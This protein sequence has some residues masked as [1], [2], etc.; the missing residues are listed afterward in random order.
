MQATCSIEGCNHRHQARG[1]CNMHYRRVIKTGSPGQA[2]TKR[3]RGRVCSVD[4][5]E[6]KAEANAMCGMHYARVAKHGAPGPVE[7]LRYGGLCTVDGCDRKAKARKLCGGHYGQQAAGRPFAPVRDS[8]IGKAHERDEQGN[9]Q[10]RECRGWF[11]E[12]AYTR[13]AKSQDGLA[14]YC[15]SCRKD[16]TLRIAHGITLAQYEERLASQ[17]GACA[18]CGTDER[19]QGREYHVDH[20]HRCCPGRKGCGKCIRGLLCGP[21]NTGIGMLGE[22]A[23][24]MWAAMMYLGGGTP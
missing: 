24:R 22:D 10:C 7:S 1:Y 3:L 19:A 12:G 15:S 2:E 13:S 21:C 11:P 5:C 18:I 16:R 17:G 9:K 4:G 8:W 6:R 14:P 20:D 23:G